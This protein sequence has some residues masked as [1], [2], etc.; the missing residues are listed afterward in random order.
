MRVRAE[1][2]KRF[3]ERVFQKMGISEEDARITAAVL[4]A[5]D[6]RGIDSHGV[7][8]LRRYVNG[9]RDGMIV[10]CPQVRVMTET[11]VTALIDAGAGLGQ[12]ISRRAMQKA[13]QKAQALGAGFVTVRNSNHYGI[14][15]Y[16]AMMALEHDC[17]GI[18]MTNASVLVVPTFG[19]DAMLGTNPISVAAPAGQEWPFVLDMATSTVPRGKL[20]VYDRL[21]KPLPLG[22]ATD[23]TGI[24][25]T[26]TGRVLKNFR[27]KKKGSGGLL[28][29]G[30][31]GELLGGHKG[32]GLA[33]MVEILC[34]I[35]SGSAYADLVYPK[36]PDGKPLPSNVGHF[37][38]AWRVD[39]F[40]PVEEFKAAM[41][42]L[43]RRFKNAPRAEGQTRIYI[44]GEKEYEEAERRSREGIPLNPKVA[45]DL[46]ALGEE[47]GV[48]YA[49]H[50][51]QHPR[52]RQ[53]CCRG[54]R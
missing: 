8:R 49:G 18:S 13:I 45:A 40:R 44:H 35:L 19:R 17:I 53:G 30:G 42:D 50:P 5:A 29:L 36:T 9:L 15:G 33:L 28:P 12:P 14:A 6:L 7:A 24:P 32:Y 1:S 47:M 39:A 37:F 38:G 4:V 2:L 16:Y 20:E 46:R 31:A 41:D 21:E 11:P 43:Q 27:D 51:S 48:E 54:P 25:T 26:D 23:E 10:A 52:V 22:W 34:A 3:C